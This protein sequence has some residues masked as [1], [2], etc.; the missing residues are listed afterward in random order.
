MVYLVESEGLKVLFGQ[1]VHGPIHESLRSNRG[2]YIK[3]L[4]LLLS[5]QADVLCEGHYG[6]FK[7]KEAEY[8]NRL[9]EF[10]YLAIGPT[11]DT[12]STS[13]HIQD[14]IKG[15]D[16]LPLDQGLYRYTYH[17]ANQ[18]SGTYRK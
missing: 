5:L 17:R 4:K 13:C 11:S 10:T 7:G 3:S 14:I 12:A 15:H 16:S 9:R 8:L 18:N 1:D 2:D 6:I